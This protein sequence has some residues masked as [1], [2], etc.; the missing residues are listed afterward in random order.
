MSLIVAVFLATQ[1][2]YAMDMSTDS[3]D[4]AAIAKVCTHA[5]FSQKSTAHKKFWLDCMKPVILGQAVKGVTVDATVVK[6]C[7]TDKISQ[8][9]E[10]LKEL[11]SA[12]E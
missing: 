6:A 12:S 8:L 11:Q 1:M 9:Q 5:G 7:R 3:K 4:C 2:A 10:E